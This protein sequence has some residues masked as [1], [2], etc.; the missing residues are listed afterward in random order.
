MPEKWIRGRDGILYCS[1]CGVKQGAWHLYWCP[2]SKA[3]LPKS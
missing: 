3:E 2:Y 1:E